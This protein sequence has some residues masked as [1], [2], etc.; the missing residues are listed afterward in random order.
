MPV[1]MGIN[2][3]NIFSNNNDV[4]TLMEYTS[5][6]VMTA[7]DVSHIHY[8]KFINT[9]D[10]LISGHHRGNN[11]CPLIGGV[12]LLESSIFFATYGLERGTLKVLCF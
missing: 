7:C 2:Y 8:H 11:I 3:S 6:I 10:S 4:C 12:R 1:F 9:V 5:G